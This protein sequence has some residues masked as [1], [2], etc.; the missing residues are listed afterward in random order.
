[1]LEENEISFLNTQEQKKAKEKK[2]IQKYFSYLI[3]PILLILLLIIVVH[4][5]G[6]IIVA[7]LFNCKIKLISYNSKAIFIQ[8]ETPTD[9]RES[10]IISLSGSLF[11]CLIALIIIC[12]LNSK[13]F[14]KKEL[15]IFLRI[16]CYIDIIIEILYWFI[17]PLLKQGDGYDFIMYSQIPLFYYYLII[18]PSGIIVILFYILE[19]TKFTKK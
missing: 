11:S 7:L 2:K 13:K 18:I 16:A 10:A 12:F 17:S 9:R 15:F 14:K 19:M 5:L 6:H 3:L 4:E 1:M 8:H